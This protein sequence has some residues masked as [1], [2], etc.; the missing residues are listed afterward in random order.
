LRIHIAVCFYSQSEDKLFLKDFQNF[1]IIPTLDK[2]IN[3]VKPIIGLKSYSNRVGLKID[4]IIINPL[5]TIIFK[6]TPQCRL[7]RAI[8]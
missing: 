4:E 2:K 7:S 8:R 6:G 3:N 5:T 1:I